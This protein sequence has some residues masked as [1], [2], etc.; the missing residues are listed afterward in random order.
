MALV[1]P[2]KVRAEH[3]R[4]AERPVDVRLG[5]LHVKQD[6]AQ[7]SHRRP[8]SADPERADILGHDEAA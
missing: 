7:V 1:L 8:Q 4:R 3:A 2:R 6:G 5:R